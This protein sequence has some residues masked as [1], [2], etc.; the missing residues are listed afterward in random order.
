MSIKELEKRRN[1]YCKFT[2]PADWEANIQNFMTEVINTFKE[3]SG[4]KEYKRWKI[5]L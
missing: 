1:E 3:L 5:K 4:K 2:H